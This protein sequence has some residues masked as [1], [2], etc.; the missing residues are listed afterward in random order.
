MT[1]AI[2]HELALTLLA[3]LYVDLDFRR[4]FEADPMAAMH[5]LG[6]PAAMRAPLATLAGTT[7]DR[8]GG[9]ADFHRI[10]RL[11]EHL[12]WVDLARRPSLAPTVGAYFRAVRPRL[13]N[14][15]EC[16]AFCAFVEALRAHE[17]PYLADL[18]RFERRRIEVAWGLA[19]AASRAGEA[20]AY[21]VLAILDALDA[22]GAAATDD[23]REWPDLAPEPCRLEIKKV[24][25]SPAVLVRALPA[26]VR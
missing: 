24:P 1:A 3:R 22:P 2:D 5:A 19:G 16:L 10:A 7:L 14:R 11:E 9:M 15:E 23:G 13:T 26:D 8:I 20:F 17:P 21:P 6:V 25:L 12:A 18:A 4:A